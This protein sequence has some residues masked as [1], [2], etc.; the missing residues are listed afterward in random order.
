MQQRRAIHVYAHLTF[1]V[2]RENLRPDAC[3]AKVLLA[4]KMLK[5]AVAETSANAFGIISRH[6]F[7]ARALSLE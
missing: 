5:R 3:S 6:T 1:K 4:L 2:L 7:K